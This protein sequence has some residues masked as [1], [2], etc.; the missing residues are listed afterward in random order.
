VKVVET[1]MG[2]IP[3]PGALFGTRGVPTSAATV[4]RPPTAEG[5][6]GQDTA[7]LRLAVSGEY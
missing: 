1:F 4:E 2:D 5:A 6:N 7:L 3:R